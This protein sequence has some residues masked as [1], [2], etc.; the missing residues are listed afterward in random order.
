MSEENQIVVTRTIDAPSDA[1]FD[2]LSLP[3]RHKEFDGSGMIVADDHTQR[4]SAV[5]DT[6]TMNM[7]HESQGGDYQMENHVV[8]FVDNQLIGWAPARPGEKPAGWKWVYMLKAKSS[9][10]TDVTLTYDWANVEDPELAAMFPAVPEKALE[11]S[12]NLLAAAVA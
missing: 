9:H 10:V 7:H 12:L 1:L 5:G 3:A 11:E 2:L 6:F 8:T 4:L